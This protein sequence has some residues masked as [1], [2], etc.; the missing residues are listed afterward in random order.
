MSLAV[1]CSDEKFRSFRS[2]LDEVAIKYKYYMRE[3][4]SEKTTFFLELLPITEKALQIIRDY[5]E[6]KGLKVAIEIDTETYNLLEGNL[7]VL[8]EKA[9]EAQERGGLVRGYHY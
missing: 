7:T 9:K 2:Y 4:P 6:E 5:A 3:E 1:E 8:F